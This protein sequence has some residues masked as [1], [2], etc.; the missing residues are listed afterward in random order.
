MLVTFK[1]TDKLKTY[2]GSCTIG[3]KYGMLVIDT[4][5]T[6]DLP[7]DKAL[8]VCADFPDN[9]SSD[10]PRVKEAKGA[11]V[12]QFRPLPVRGRAKPEPKPEKDEGGEKGTQAPPNNKSAS[13]PQANK[14]A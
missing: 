13:A 5:G 6:Y 14:G 11:T 8:Q 4:V 10:D 7:D 2:Q 9:F 12:D 1:Q 3:D